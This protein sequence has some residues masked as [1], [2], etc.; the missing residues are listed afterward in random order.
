MLAEGKDGEVTKAI[1]ITCDLIGTD[2]NRAHIPK[3]AAKFT[4]K[5][6]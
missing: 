4:I 5:E 6:Y 3:S 2:E 1:P